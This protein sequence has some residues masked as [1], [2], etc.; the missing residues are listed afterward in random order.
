VRDVVVASRGKMKKSGV[1]GVWN[2]VHL[3]IWWATSKERNRRIF[4][5]KAL[6][7]QDYKFYFSVGSMVTKT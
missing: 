5:D 7:S 1:L 2:I 6:S 3:A 4:E